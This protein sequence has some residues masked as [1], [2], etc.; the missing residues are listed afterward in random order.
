MKM[1]CLMWETVSSDKSQSTTRG[2]KFACHSVV[3]LVTFHVDHPPCSPRLFFLLLPL[4]AVLLK[5]CFY[6]LPC[7]LFGWSGV[8]PS[9]L[10]AVRLRWCVSVSLAGC[11]V[12]VVF[13]CLPCRLSGW[14][15]VWP[16]PLQAVSDG[17]TYHPGAFGCLSC[18]LICW[19][20]FYFSSFAGF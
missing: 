11:L 2:K 18:R 1:T 3:L 12:E 9:P 19:S 17:F 20:G 10:Q 5:W 13:D 8:W 6:H 16:F 7:S 15:G 4:Q 14:G